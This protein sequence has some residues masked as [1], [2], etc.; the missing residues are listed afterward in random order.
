[1]AGPLPAPGLPDGLLRTVEEN[2]LVIEIISKKIVFI[3]IAPVLLKILSFFVPR[4]C[5]L[6]LIFNYGNVA[7]DLRKSL[8]MRRC[9]L[10]A[11]SSQ[12]SPCVAWLTCVLCYLNSYVTLVFAFVRSASWPFSFCVVRFVIFTF[13]DSCADSS[14]SVHCGKLEPI[15]QSQ[16]ITLAL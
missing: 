6:K 12:L 4:G 13:N 8:P 9:F 15:L 1:V 5:N 10:H 11:A 3:V 2:V 14:A 7:P 16:V